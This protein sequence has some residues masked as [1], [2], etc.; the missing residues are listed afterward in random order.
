[1]DDLPLKYS[2]QSEFHYQLLQAETASIWLRIKPTFYLWNIRR[3]QYGRWTRQRIVCRVR[4]ILTLKRIG[5]CRHARML[6]KNMCAWPIFHRRIDLS[7]L[8][9]KHEM[10]MDQF[11]GSL[12]MLE[13][14]QSVQAQNMHEFLIEGVI[15]D[16]S[17]ENII[18]RYTTFRTVYLILAFTQLQE[19]VRGQSPLQWLSVARQLVSKS[20]PALCK[21]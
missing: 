1:M 7:V 11:Q 9:P 8:S 5:S 19:D 3:K 4:H 2:F 6:A 17:H 13:N 18:L 20:E 14:V 15:W 21:I 10:K 12:Q 16:K